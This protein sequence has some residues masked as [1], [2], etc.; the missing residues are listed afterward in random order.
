M[1]REMQV[2]QRLWPL[3][4]DYRWI[5]LTTVGLGI[6]ASLSEGIGISLMIPLLQSLELE[7]FKTTQPQG[8]VG[9]LERPLQEF[10]ADHRLIIISVAITIA[11]LLKNVL[12]YINKALFS[13]FSQRVGHQLRSKIF[14]QI[15]NIHYT[16]IE[17][18]DSGALLNIL[19]TESWQVSSALEMLVNIV[20]SACTL[21]VFALILFLLSWRLTIVVGLVTLLISALGRRLTRQA[22]VLGQQ[23]VKTNSELAVLMCEGLMGMRTIRSF[24]REGYEQTRFDQVSEKVKD[25]F[26]R[27]ELLY[28]MVDPLHEGLSTFLVV[29]VLVFSLLRD[30]STLSAILTFMFMLYRL[31]PQIKLIDLYRLKLLAAEGAI[32]TVMGFI[33]TQDKPYPALGYRPFDRLQQSITF[34]RVGFRYGASNSPALRNLSLQILSGKTTALVGPSGA[35]K[36]TLINLICRFYD[37]TA[38]EICVDGYSLNS[39]D[40]RDWRSR[41]AIVNQ[42]IH[43]FSTT[44]RENIAYGRLEASDQDIL[45]AAKQAHAHEFIADLPLG[46]D[47]PVGDRGFRLSGG[48]RQR[49]ALARAIVRDPDI[50]ILDEATN[51]L[52]TLSEHLIQAALEKFSRDRTVIVIAHRLSTIEQADKIVVLD[53]GEIVEQGTLSQL[54]SHKGLFNQLYQLQYRHALPNS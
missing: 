49:I 37:V 36:S 54:L 10:S 5:A 14:S 9:F 18:K 42:D 2:A 44:I 23:A 27:I 53:K 38:G 15:L 41:I 50:L 17:T 43:I 47:T 39:L 26:W 6:L 1:R 33:E 40:L 35:G 3:T 48:Q 28:S 12:A 32:D 29:G 7:S 20:I 52:D 13:W 45:T 24:S 34:D 21:V 11:I 16:Y 30:P 46:Y 19:A 51:A 25:I 22:K 31:Q 8:W 4:E